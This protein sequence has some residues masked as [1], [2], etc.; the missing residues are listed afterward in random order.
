MLSV[1]WT[2]RH[3]DV[4]VIWRWPLHT[5]HTRHEIERRKERAVTSQMDSR[6]GV[7]LERRS[8][9]DVVKSVEAAHRVGNLGAAPAPSTVTPCLPSARGNRHATRNHRPNP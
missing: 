8:A 6:G 7:E 4:S 5:R 1:W 9:R 2:S 3:V